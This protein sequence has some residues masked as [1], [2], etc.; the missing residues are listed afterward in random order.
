MC[1]ACRCCWWQGSPKQVGSSA[2]KHLGQGQLG[3]LL[4][5]LD[6][7]TAQ[8]LLGKTDPGLL[9]SLGWS[10]DLDPRIVE[11]VLQVRHHL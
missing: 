3:G 9:A 2:Q 8:A 5:G 11:Q 6:T 1:L 4:G 7:A 10:G